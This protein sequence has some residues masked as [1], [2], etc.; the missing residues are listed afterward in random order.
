MFQ[1]L[2]DD[3]VLYFICDKTRVTEVLRIDYRVNRE[4]LLLIQI[5]TP[6]YCTLFRYIHHQQKRP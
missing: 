6:V 3:G 2:V 5:L 4:C 1:K